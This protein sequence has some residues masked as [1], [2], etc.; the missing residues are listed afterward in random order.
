MVACAR[1]GTEN[2]EGARFCSACGASLAAGE[3][4]VRKTVTV[5]F[6]DL[7]GSTALGERLD[8][9]SVRRL[10]GR[11]FDEARATLGTLRQVMKYAPWLND[12]ESQ[13]FM[14]EAVEL[15]EG[16]RGRSQGSG[17]RDQKTRF[18]STGR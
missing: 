9:E 17:V 5:V 4:E 7:S 3:S 12:A 1:C 8:A 18:N 2:P 14:S 11:Y 6:N 16:A 15:I 13:G 10:L